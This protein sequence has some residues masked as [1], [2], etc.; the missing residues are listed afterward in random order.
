MT[1]AWAVVD[2]VDMPEGRPAAPPVAAKSTAPRRVAPSHAPGRD[3]MWPVSAREIELAI[4]Q[5]LPA[6]AADLH[7]RFSDALAAIARRWPDAPHVVTGYAAH[8]ADR[9]ARQG[10]PDAALARLHAEELFLAWWAGTG[11]AA[12]LT[13]FDAEFGGEVAR[14]AARFP[15]FPSDELI[16]QLRVKLFVGATA[17]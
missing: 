13:A 5:R 3:M 1:L 16:Q 8:V 7:A 6:C 12:G 2:R 15:Q 17:K 4:R 10:D 14:L 11:A 9:L